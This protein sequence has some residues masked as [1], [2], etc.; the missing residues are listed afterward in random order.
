MPTPF[1]HLYIAEKMAAR[2]AADSSAAQDGSGPHL[3]ALLQQQWPAFYL[4]QVA[5]DVQDVAGLPRTATHFYSVPPEEGNL[6]YP[7]LLAQYPQLADVRQMPLPQAVF[8][9]GYSAHLLLDLIWFRE[10]LLPY[11]VEPV[12]LGDFSRRDYLHHILLIYLDGLAHAGLPATAV[13]TLAAARPQQWLPFVPDRHLQ[14]WRDTLAAQLKPGA[15]LETMTVYARRLGISAASFAA[16]LSDPGWMSDHF[17]ALVPVERVQM[18]LETAVTES[19]AVV[20]NYLQPL[21]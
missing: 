5:P 10:I 21:L 12:S 6:A 1:T 13:S 4:G 19:I 8:I 16:Q 15:P 7:R 9:A 3:L 18:R 11:F 17:F 20:Q 14:T 2:L